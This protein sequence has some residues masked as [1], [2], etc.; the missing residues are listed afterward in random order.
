MET[1]MLSGA[2]RYVC[3]GN[4]PMRG[5]EYLYSTQDFKHYLWISG[6]SFRVQNYWAQE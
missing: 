3:M 4:L 6:I 2:Y 1:Y 5:I